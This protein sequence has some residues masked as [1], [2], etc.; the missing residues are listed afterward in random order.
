MIIITKMT[1]KHTNIKGFGKQITNFRNLYMVKKGPKNSSS[2][3]P[4][5]IR[6]MPQRKHF[7]FREVFPNGLCHRWASPANSMMYLFWILALRDNY[8]FFLKIGNNILIGCAQHQCEMRVVCYMLQKFRK[9]V[10]TKIW[11]SFGRK[12]WISMFVEL[13]NMERENLW[14]IFCWRFGQE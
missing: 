11:F 8:F 12:C 3:L 9:A 13:G 7:V 2:G 1:K 10:G 6:A 4:P 5:L 14:V